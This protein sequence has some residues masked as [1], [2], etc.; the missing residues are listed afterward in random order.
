M[1]F[2]NQQ[3]DAVPGLAGPEELAAL[4]PKTRLLFR[5]AL[6]NHPDLIGSLVSQRPADLDHK[7]LAI[8]SSWQHQIFGKFFVFRQLKK[9]MVFLSA[10]SLEAEPSEGSTTATVRRRSS[11]ASSRPSPS[12]ASLAARA[13]PSRSKHV[14]W[15]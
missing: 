7:E 2:V 4:T 12:R 13:R 9:Y 14:G 15:R 11:K 5:R 6:L 8:V 1:Y 3:C 10:S